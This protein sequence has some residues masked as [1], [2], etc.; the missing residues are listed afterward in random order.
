MKIRT[1]FV[2]N[3]SSSCFVVNKKYV[4]MTKKMYE[5]IINEIIDEYMA[6]KKELFI[7]EI[8]KYEVVQS[9][10]DRVDVDEYDLYDLYDNYIYRDYHVSNLQYLE[11]LESINMIYGE[12]LRDLLDKYELEFRKDLDKWT[13]VIDIRND[14]LTEEEIF[15]IAITLEY[16]MERFSDKLS[17]KELSYIK[18]NMLHTEG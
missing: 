18:E 3:S 8:E 10:E 16:I 14:K 15:N 6:N 17:E 4:N 1:D 5:A 9:E 12:N 7:E 13:K 11:D 2:T